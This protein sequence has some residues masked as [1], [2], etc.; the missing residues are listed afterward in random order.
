MRGV[1]RAKHYSYRTEQAYVRWAERFI[2]F[3]GKRHPREM[4]KHEMEAFLADLDVRRQVA[5][6]TLNYALNGILYLVLG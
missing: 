6:A 3:Q 4:G 5:A 1:I 2:L